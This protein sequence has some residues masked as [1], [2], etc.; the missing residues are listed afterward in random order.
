M[1]TSVGTEQKSAAWYRTPLGGTWSGRMPGR[2]KELC[3]ART[4]RATPCRAEA[5]ANGRCRL[6]G[7][8][9]TGP[10]T[11]EG[12]RRIA[13]AQRRRRAENRARKT[14]E[15]AELDTNRGRRWV[16]SQFDE[17]P[18]IAISGRWPSRTAMSAYSQKRTFSR[19]AL[20]VRL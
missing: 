4:R 18:L 17:G 16:V 9:S 20:D 10:T 7:G 8:R 13:E 15:H 12:R 14:A 11:A 3:G 2:L 5:L 6:H 19:L 1:S